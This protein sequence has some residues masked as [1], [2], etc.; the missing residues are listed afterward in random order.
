[1]MTAREVEKKNISIQLLLVCFL[2][3][4]MIKFQL[5]FKF[6]VWLWWQNMISGFEPILQNKLRGYT[7]GY[8]VSDFS[9]GHFNYVVIAYKF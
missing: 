7:M 8:K 9:I 3:F 2:L 4:H 5:S 6:C 1:M